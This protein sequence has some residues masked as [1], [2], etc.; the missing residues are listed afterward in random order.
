[1]PMKKL[2][3]ASATLFCAVGLDVAPA[4]AAT[5]ECGQSCGSI[6]SS[7]L[8]E[9]GDYGP[10]ETV[11]DGK[12]QLGQSVILKPITA[13]D[14]SQDIIPQVTSAKGA[15]QKGLVGADV[16][17]QYGDLPAVQ[18]VFAPFGIKTSFCVGLDEAPH[19]NQGL[20][21]Q[22]C[23]EESSVWILDF[24]NGSGAFFPI[25]NAAT[26]DFERP[27]AMDLRRNQIVSGR[28]TPQI[29]VRRYKYLGFE[30]RL[31]ATQLWGFVQGPLS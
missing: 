14:S 9:Q 20:S 24:P 10:I 8:S 23:N 13:G 11:L 1:M 19:Q 22:S 17:A 21:L 31:P 6:Y 30:K 7:E 18:Q 26:Q 15:Y 16:A 28:N 4:S 27:Y 25:V 3:L 5:P 12:A 2:L 29:V